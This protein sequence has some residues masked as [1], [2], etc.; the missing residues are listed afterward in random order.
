[1]TDTVSRKR[2]EVL[3][4]QPLVQRVIDAALQVGVKGY[5]VLPTL[6][7]AGE[8]GD[9]SEDQL[10]G[11]LSKV[12]FA[13]VTHEERAKQ[14]IDRLTPLLETYGIVVLVSDVQV[15]RGAKF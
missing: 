7:G 15:I 13:T 11:A 10:S 2:I 5:T 4:D 12:M 6:S 14:L 8:G 3:V 1:M 9:W